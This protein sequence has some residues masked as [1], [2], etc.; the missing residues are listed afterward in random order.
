MRTAASTYVGDL[1]SPLPTG[2]Q[3]VCPTTS[4][5]KI[6]AYTPHVVKLMILISVE[7]ESLE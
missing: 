7:V 3:V 1:K 5:W 6:P 2:I 4:Y